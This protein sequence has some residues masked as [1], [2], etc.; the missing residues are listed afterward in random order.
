MNLVGLKVMVRPDSVG[1]VE[2]EI[3]GKDRDRTVKREIL[4]GEIH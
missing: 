2:L 4:F 1:V 3:D